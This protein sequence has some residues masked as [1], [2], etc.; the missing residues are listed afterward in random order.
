LADTAVAPGAQ[1]RGLLVLALTAVLGGC[2]IPGGPLLP[3]DV[4]PQRL[5]RKAE[6]ARSFDAQ[7]DQAEFTDALTSWRQGDVTVCRQTLDRLLGRNALHRD[8]ALLRAEVARAESKP[9]DAFPHLERLAATQPDDAEVQ[10]A[11]ARLRQEVETSAVILAG[12]REPLP[13]SF[14]DGSA[15]GDDSTGQENPAIA[16]CLAAAGECL[17]AGDAAG[18]ARL[19]ERGVQDHPRSAA[20]YRTMGLAYYRQGDYPSAERALRQSLSLVNSS[21]LAYFLLGSALQRLGHAEDAECFRRARS[22]DVRF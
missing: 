5:E 4:G 15:E 21:A 12:H 1:R 11:L 9:A 7:R 13:T 6:A 8:A 22:L 20:L 10:R 14:V 2:A 19:A 3:A 18:A 17:R 16:E